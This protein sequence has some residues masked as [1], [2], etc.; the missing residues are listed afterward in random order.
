MFI[1]LHVNNTK[2]FHSKQV[3]KYSG[4]YFFINI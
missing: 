1:M 2:F 3:K 4:I